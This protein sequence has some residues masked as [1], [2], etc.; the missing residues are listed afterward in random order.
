M[1]WFLDDASCEH[2]RLITHEF[3]TPVLRKMFGPVRYRLNLKSSTR[4]RKTAKLRF[5]LP[6]NQIA[7][8]EIPVTELPH[9]CP[10]YN[11]KAPGLT[12]GLPPS[13]IYEGTFSAGYSFP[14]I[15]ALY[16]GAIGLRVSYFTSQFGRMLAKIAHAFI[17]AEY[18]DLNF[19]PM[20]L[21]II[22]G[23]S[24]TAPYLIGGD[25]RAT[26]PDDGHLL[27][28]IH[29]LDFQNSAGNYVGV[30]IRL[31]AALSAPRY[32]VVVG[33]KL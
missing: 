3:E 8:K 7:E 9:V 15:A 24:L 13:D 28:Q 22:L 4:G 23:R 29:R 12:R 31:F 33:E 16:P 25:E 6:G 19:K 21:D 10:G 26:Q 5:I 30:S 20:L 1:D 14:E 2:C 17:V 27:H 11:W 18:P 32:F